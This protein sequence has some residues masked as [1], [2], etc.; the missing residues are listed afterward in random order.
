LWTFLTAVSAVTDEAERARLTVTFLPSLVP[1]RLSGIGLLDEESQNWQPIFQLDGEQLDADRSATFLSEL[2]PILEHTARHPAVAVVASDGDADRLG[3]PA[4]LVEHGIGCLAVGAL[5]TLRHRIGVLVVGRAALE[6]FSPDEEMLLSTLGEHLAIGLENL[7]FAHAV[8]EHSRRLADIYNNTPV[9]MHSID[10]DGALIRVNDHWLRVLGYERDEV[11]GRRS[12]DFLTEQSRWQAEE[13]ALPQ[14]RETG[15]V[16]NIELQFVKKDGDVIDVLLSAIAE[17]DDQGRIDHTLAFLVDVSERKR[18]EDAQRAAEEALR[19]SEERYRD[20]Y[21]N[22]PLAYDTVGADGR[23]Q[24]T[25]AYSARMLGVA[26]EDLIGRHVLDLYA[27]TPSGRQKA[28]QLF[29]RFLAG[30]ELRDQELEMR[31]A[32]GQSIWVS[33]TVRP[34]R[35]PQGKVL[36]SRSMLVDITERKLAEQAL[37][38]SEERF[39]GIFR[40]AMDAIV[41]V[42]GEGR[43][44]LFNDAAENVFRC[45]ASTVLGQP[46]DRL[47]S[48]AF[49]TV[50]TDCLS[51]FRAEGVSN[52]Y[53]WAPEGLTAIRAN[54]EEFPVEATISRVE[55][56][57]QEL[58]SI[59]LRDINERQRAESELR[60]LRQETEYLQQELK[61]VQ[62][63]GEMVGASPAT[64]QV[65]DDIAQVAATDS[66]VLITGETGTGKELVAAAIHEGSLRKD[67]A[68]VTINCAALPAGLMESELFGH[69]RGAFTGA[70]SRKIG[71]FELA[72]GGSIFLD[73]IGDLPSDLQAKL[74]RVLQEGEFQRV[75]GTRTIEVGVRVIAATNRDLAKAIEEGKFRADLY[76]RLNVFPIH[77]PPLRERKDDIPLL[78]EYFLGKYSKKLGKS[79]RTIHESTMRSLLS[80]GWP[81]N[82]RELENV[83]ER[84]VVI[85]QGTT[86][87]LG[88][89]FPQAGPVGGAGAIPTLDDVQREHI[90]EVLELTGWRVAGEHGAAI[91]LGIKPTTL[92]ARMKKLGIERKR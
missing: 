82:I 51:A 23:I 37:R 9:M 13:S 57:D 52:R 28:E 48:E 6:T 1:C 12:M 16:K 70:L 49:R 55:V 34:I 78:A 90:R 76:Y 53:L 86:L 66:T 38:E 73:E 69:E 31:R 14:L 10:N 17:F 61:S 87:Q 19:A 71:R 77:V 5:R 25:N 32:D 72:D 74:L 47:L 60:K 8:E 88:K 59:I 81:G 44:S 92:E 35:D 63:V 58:C 54:G 3:V 24:M 36:A 11:I 15:S 18:A 91:T 64:K 45:S 41:I 68:L 67:K 30:E 40:S 39:A 4:S 79:I 56:P 80:Y 33:L 2:Q 7:R 29:Q 65:F 46:V 85:S 26:Q 27:D 21:E 50:L 20:L 22:A 83:I 84:G 42:D 43:I 75:G 62:H 89:W